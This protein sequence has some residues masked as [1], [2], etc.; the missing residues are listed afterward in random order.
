[1][2]FGL[3]AKDID[4]LITDGTISG[5]MIPKTCCG[6]NALKGG[7]KNVHK[8]RNTPEKLMY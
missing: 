8:S 4:N 1:L 3:T 7:V 6:T 2:D 5:G